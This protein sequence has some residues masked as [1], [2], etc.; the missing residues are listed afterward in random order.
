MKG[1]RILLAATAVLAA[2]LVLNCSKKTTAPI[3]PPDSPPACSLGS[4]SL[5]FGSVTVGSSADRTFTISNT[6]GGTL[7]GSATTTSPGYAVVAGT[8]YSLAAG[9]QA[10]VTVR[11]SPSSTGTLAG[12]VSLSGSG[13]GSVSCTGTGAPSGPVCQLSTTSLDF[14]S[15]PPG[16]CGFSSRTFTISNAGTG[17]LAG[18][19]AS[20]HSAFE[21]VGGAA[22]SLT[23]GARDTFTIRFAPSVFGDQLGR[24]VTGCDT[25]Y[26]IGRTVAVYGCAS[27]APTSLDFG[28]IYVG[29]RVTKYVTLT[30]SGSQ[31]DLAWA[32]EG[33]PNFDGPP[34]QQSVQPDDIFTLPVDFTPISEGAHSSSFQGQCKYA[35]GDG[36]YHAF[37]CIRVTGSA[38]AAPGTPQCQLSA[39]TL[40]FGAVSVGSSADR[41]LT[42]TNAGGGVLN[43]SVA[44]P[45][46]TEFAVIGDPTVSLGPGQSAVY[47]IRFSPPQS[48]HAYT[49]YVFAFDPNC[50]VVTLTGQGQ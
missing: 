27:L 30:S 45:G 12:T 1:S 19:V 2:S 39:T 10:T 16:V 20:L 8:P 4:S 7:A 5:S 21:V 3:V 36:Q 15:V 37:G 17:T 23:P 22:Y 34:P 47:T 38:V 42:V 9:Q 48:G 46:C 29:Q 43:G 18:T 40:N 24:V 49:C 26:C 25:V 33:N 50:S 11:F 13:C 44:S 32:G 28:S 35:I 6:G 41:T 14:G 31:F